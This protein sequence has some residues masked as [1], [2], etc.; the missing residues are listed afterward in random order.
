MC[1]WGTHRKCMVAIPETLSHTVSVRDA[2][3]D[4]DECIADIV[5]ALNRGGVLTANSCCGHNKADGS[6]LLHDGRELI[7]KLALKT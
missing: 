3:V 5:D 2:W 7:I 1:M 4:V 6:I